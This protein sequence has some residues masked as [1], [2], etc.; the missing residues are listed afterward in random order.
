MLFLR[1]KVMRVLFFLVL[2]GTTQ[3]FVVDAIDELGLR[4][5]L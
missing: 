4:G 2:V 1:S 5:G 3:E